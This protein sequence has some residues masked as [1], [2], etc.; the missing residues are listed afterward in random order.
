MLIREGGSMKKFSILVALLGAFLYYYFFLSEYASFSSIQNYQH[1]LQVYVHGQ[2]VRSVLLYMVSYIV[3]VAVSLPVAVLFTLLGGSLFGALWGTLYAVVSATTGATLS[4]LMVRYLLGQHVQKRYEKNLTLLNKEFKQRGLYYLL[5]LRLFPVIPFFVLTILIALTNVPLCTFV[6]TT[7]VG[8]LPGT[9]VY[10][11]AGQCLA[12]LESPK[13]ILSPPLLVAF[14]LL[15][16]LALIPVLFQRR[17]YA[18][19][20]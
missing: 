16:L 17:R 15:G 11:Y 5:S 19:R 1:T 14:I 12:T 10:T 3:V 18:G 8:I 9:F 6:L 20:Y 4:F 13:D 7:L 2:Y